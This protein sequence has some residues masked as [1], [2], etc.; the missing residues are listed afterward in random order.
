MKKWLGT[1]LAVTLTVAPVAYGGTP[2]SVATTASC[3]VLYA[4]LDALLEASGAYS[5]RFE[6]RADEY[7]ELRDALADLRL[8]TV[9]HAGEE[10]SPLPLVQATG[11]RPT[12]RTVSR[13]EAAPLVL[14]GVLG[15]ALGGLLIY[16]AIDTDNSDDAATGYVLGGLL[17]VAGVLALTNE[18]TVREEVT[19]QAAVQANARIRNEVE[20][21]N[22]AIRA[23][24]TARRQKL[25]ERESVESE[26][27][28]IERER[29]RLSTLL[30]NYEQ[31]SQAI[32]EST[33]VALAGEGSARCIDA[34]VTSGALLQLREPF[35]NLYLVTR[36]LNR[37]GAVLADATSVSSLTFTVTHA[38]LSDP[39][40]TLGRIDAPTRATLLPADR[41]GVRDRVGDGYLLRVPIRLTEEVA[42]PDRIVAEAEVVAEQDG[43]TFTDRS[44]LEVHVID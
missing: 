23:E 24:N 7:L 28:A 43:R 4:E 21:E 36:P 25:A 44:R 15:L 13:T 20:E 16:S 30:S 9:P 31:E 22:R 33:V 19:D 5:L 42:E 8:Q 6:S 37:E 34:L 1:L 18:R 38:V 10:L 29:A 12:T 11:L 3:S 35:A 39:L 41:L 40:G 14:Q 27:E 2:F 32:Y 17:V 26:N